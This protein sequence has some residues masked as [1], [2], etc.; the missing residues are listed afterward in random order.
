MTKASS[1]VPLVLALLTA[2]CMALPIGLDVEA[3]DVV[4]SYLRQDCGTGERK[5]SISAVVS[6]RER[7]I[8]ILQRA[9]KEGPPAEEREALLANARNDCARLKAYVA[10]G[11]LRDL[12]NADVVKAAREL[13]EGACVA[14]RVDG[15]DRAWRERGINGLAAIGGHAATTALDALARS[16]DLEPELRARA[17]EGRRA[18]SRTVRPARR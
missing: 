3:R 8:P 18:A 5:A 7:A 1:F 15:F 13:D 2:P 4:D 10:E 14:M 17:A 12:K 9:V 11:G 16:T 6:L